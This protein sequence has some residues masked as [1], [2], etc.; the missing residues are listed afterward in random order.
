LFEGAAYPTRSDDSSRV[1]VA[2]IACGCV[3][4]KLQS[5]LSTFNTFQLVEFSPKHRSFS[6]YLRHDF[7]TILAFEEDATLR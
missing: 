3:L 7:G 4:Y 1:I 5:T 2:G 6:T